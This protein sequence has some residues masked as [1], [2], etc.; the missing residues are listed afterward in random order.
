MARREWIPSAPPELSDAYQEVGEK[1]QRRGDSTAAFTGRDKPNAWDQLA[2]YARLMAETRA[3]NDDRTVRLAN[4]TARG[5][6]GGK[7]PYDEVVTDR[8]T[9]ELWQENG[10]AKHYSRIDD[11]P[12]LVLPKGDGTPALVTA[13]DTKNIGVDEWRWIAMASMLLDLPRPQRDVFEM[14][15]GGLM[16]PEEI[17]DLLGMSVEQVN[18]NYYRAKKTLAR[19]AA[20]LEHIRNGGPEPE[21]KAGRAKRKTG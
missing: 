9:L 4:M 8:E 17:A 6:D 20:L 3:R 5:G 16:Q 12:R 21:G 15:V 11:G 2:D 14:R 1:A 13:A 7:T 19:K 10:V 18:T